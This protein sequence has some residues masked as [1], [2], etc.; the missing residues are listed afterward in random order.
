[1]DDI[2]EFS[3]FCNINS[4]PDHCLWMVFEELSLEQI[5]SLR[6]VCQRWR[7][8][9]DHIFTRQT[10]L[11]L[12]ATKT[13]FVRFKQRQMEFNLN[14]TTPFGIS[15]N[16]V[17]ILKA[18]NVVWSETLV[19]HFPNVEVLLMECSGNRNLQFDLTE[20]IDK[21]QKTIKHLTLVGWSNLCSNKFWNIIN[22]I[23]HL[24]VMFLFGLYRNRIPD[25][26]TRFKQ[27]KH[28]ALVHY[29]HDVVPI[30]RQLGPN[31]KFVLIS[32]I[33]LS[34]SQLKQIVSE[35]PSITTSLEFLRLGY[36]SSVT[37]HGVDREKNFRS[38]LQ[39]FDDLLYEAIHEQLLLHL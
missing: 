1:M 20:A 19:R 2:N 22:S 14:R 23:E 31:L 6:R 10:N 3:P 38:I 33:Y 16:E 15:N 26:M 11:K 24:E 5:I 4:L 7:C 12:F 27:I 29:L 25:G 36:I 8:L 35:N 32:W 18:K 21:W 17:L 30:F 28:F 13:D 9:I 39:Y 37:D 34:V